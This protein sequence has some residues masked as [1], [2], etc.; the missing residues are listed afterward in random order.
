M[1]NHRGIHM[2]CAFK[3]MSETRCYTVGYQE[4]LYRGKWKAHQIL[5]L[6]IFYPKW[7]L[8]HILYIVSAAHNEY[9]PVLVWLQD[10]SSMMLL[11]TVQ[12]ILLQNSSSTLESK[13]EIRTLTISFWSTLSS[14]FTI[15]PFDCSVPNFRK[16]S[17][18]HFQVAYTDYIFTFAIRLINLGRLS[19]VLIGSIVTNFV[20]SISDKWTR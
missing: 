14:R 15:L 11:Y 3:S 5:C 19:G 12:Y 1:W 16:F 20:L 7:N 8:K 2:L 10:R 9:L 13:I 4:N 6:S 18:N 17:F